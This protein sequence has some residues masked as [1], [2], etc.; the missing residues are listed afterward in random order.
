MSVA[1]QIAELNKLRP[2]ASATRTLDLDGTVHRDLYKQVR[3]RM[4]SLRS[5]IR[6]SQHYLPIRS[7]RDDILVEAG[8]TL[9]KMRPRGRNF[10]IVG[11][12]VFLTKDTDFN[13][14]VYRVGVG[15]MWSHRVYKPLYAKGYIHPEWFILAADEVRTTQKCTRVFRCIAGNLSSGDV[16]EIYIAYNTLGTLKF[17]T[18]LTL[19]AVL[20]PVYRQIS[21][22]VTNRL[23]GSN[24]N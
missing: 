1:D 7:A 23:L 9:G 2:L 14:S 13:R 16:R 17:Q 22:E 4:K 19:S 8:S 3:A 15:Y 24:E 18:G 6:G 5:Y 20:R 12:K 21:Q 11:K 10:V